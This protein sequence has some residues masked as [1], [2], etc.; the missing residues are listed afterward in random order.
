MTDFTKIDPDRLRHGGVKWG[1]VDPGVTP[2]WVADMDFGIPPVVRHALIDAVVDETFGYPYYPLGD[3]LGAAFENRMATH[4]GWQPN[5]GRTRTYTDLIQVLQ[6]MIEHAT[7]PG[8][9]IALHVP[10]YPPFLAA[11]KRSGRTIVAIEP[12]LVDGQWAFEDDNLEERLRAAAC[13]MLVL[14]NPQNPTGRVFSRTELDTLAEL[15]ARLDLVVLSDEIHADLVHAPNKHIPFASL[16]SDAAQRTITTTSATK[17]FNIAG[18]RCAVAH[19]GPDSVWDALE[20]EPLDYFGQPSTLS[21]IA[22]ITAWTHGDPWLDDLRHQLATN[23]NRV[24]A[25]AASHPELDCVTPEAT[26]LSWINFAN[27]TIADNPATHILTRGAVL[28]SAGDEFA[29]H[30]TIDTHTYARLNFAT[31]PDTLELILDGIDQTL[32]DQPP[33]NPLPE[34]TSVK[35]PKSKNI[36]CVTWPTEQPNARLR[37]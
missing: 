4:H 16:S 37:A 29:Q 31:S 11:I 28:L 5:P 20:A 21:R 10:T 6:V 12:T 26:Y 33:T 1:Y 24:T 22:T 18:L 25:W 7:Q 17:A 30:T 14:V 15:A 32:Q 8:D 36:G 2:A 9:A 23:R 19:I 3:P 13:R 35:S 27:T 34:G